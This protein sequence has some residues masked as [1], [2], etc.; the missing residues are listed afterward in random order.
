ML[1]LSNFITASIQDTEG[2][3]L[4]SPGLDHGAVCLHVVVLNK[5]AHKFSKILQAT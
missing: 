1:C 2:R 5:G 3:M 4:T